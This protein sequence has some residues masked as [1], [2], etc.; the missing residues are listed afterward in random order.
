MDELQ[1]QPPTGAKS[2]VQAAIT[3]LG[4][5]LSKS[6]GE[7]TVVGTKVRDLIA[8]ISHL[9]PTA[10]NEQFG[11]EE[12]Q[13][14]ITQAEAPVAP[15]INA[16]EEETLRQLTEERPEIKEHVVT[17]TEHLMEFARK[18]CGTLS[19][20]S[21]L[22]QINSAFPPPP[23]AEKYA[24]QAISLLLGDEGFIVKTNQALRSIADWLLKFQ[25]DSDLLRANNIY[26]CT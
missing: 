15:T 12:V 6:R 9:E 19:V 11:A 24:H 14:T 22:H 5:F 13:T 21:V 2:V 25:S 1:P 8:K 17:Y 23:D 16:Q 4:K 3:E 18:C 10:R 26:V 7:A 20:N